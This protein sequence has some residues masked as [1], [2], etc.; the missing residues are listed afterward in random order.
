MLTALMMFGWLSQAVG[1]GQG[2]AVP[3]NAAWLRGRVRDTSGAPL[4][5]AEVTLRQGQRRWRVYTTPAG[6]FRLGPIPAGRYQLQL[7]KKGYFLLNES[8]RL[9]A[10]QNPARLQLRHEHELHQTVRVISRP[11]PIQPEA[12]A[13][14]FKLLQRNIRNLPYPNNHNLAQALPAIPGVV[15]DNSGQVHV[16]GARPQSIEYTLDGFDISDPASGTLNAR[17]N[18]D[19]VR[20]VKVESGR[21]GAQH[22]SAGAGVLALRT[23]QG[24][25]KLRF[26]TTSFLPAVSLKQGLR[27][28]NW[29]PRFTLSGPLIKNRAWFADA[30]SLQH[31]LTLVPQLPAGQNTG[32]Q[33]DGDNLFSTQFHLTPNQD[34]EANLLVNYNHDT[35]LY[36]SPFTPLPATINLNERRGFFSLKDEI[37]LGGDLIELGVADDVAAD[38][39]LPLGTATYRLTPQGPRGNYF[40]SVRQTAARGQAIANVYF[41]SWRWWGQHH[42]RLGGDWLHPTLRQRAL[43]HSFEITGAGGALLQSSSFLGPGR[44]E[45]SDMLAG[46]YVEDEWQLARGLRLQPALR[47]DHEQLAAGL[48]PAPRLALNYLPWRNDQAKFSAGWGI[49]YQPVN[50]ATYGL[51]FDQQRQDTLYNAAGQPQSPPLLMHFALPGAVLKAPRFFTG[52][53]GWRQ[54]LPGAVYLGL[55]WMERQER[56]GLA[57]ENLSPAGPSVYF[58]LQNN[59]RDHYHSFEVS[60]RRSFASAAIFGDYIRSQATSN[61]ALEYNLATTILSSQAGGPLPWDAPNRLLFWGWAPTHVWQILGSWYVEYRTGY[62]FNVLNAHEQLVGAPGRLRFPGYFS[63]NVAIEK[64]FPFHHHEWAV[65]LAIL[66]ITNHNNPDAV[67]SNTGSPGFL[68]FSGSM[69]RV[70]TARLRLVGKH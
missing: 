6:R 70:F 55:R 45:V 10:G 48:L 43:R 2:T 68:G 12:M 51:A 63:L 30:L 66:N 50:L 34:L 59:R 46:L 14:K 57:Y 23:L 18:V 53:L 17:L 35:H 31:T 29:Y 25:R 67:N 52:Y 61:Q 20:S 11:S 16:A 27:L 56:D 15:L 40:Q 65:R 28:G 32:D 47:L 60:L 3:A 49:F 44:Y 37:T 22:P 1:A 62:P 19:A 4:S 42:L 5:A 24:G 26:G 33:W 54:K 7:Q 69:G 13:H 64:R 36:L 38:A 58:L 39:L 41:S 9:Q 8:V 21:F